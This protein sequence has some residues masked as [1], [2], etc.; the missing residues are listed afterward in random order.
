MIG[1]FATTRRG[2]RWTQWTLIFFAVFSFLVLLTARE[3]HHPILKRRRARQLGHTA[4]PRMPLGKMVSM[5]LT[6]SLVRPVRMLFTEPIVG[7]VCLYCSCEFATLFSFFASVPYVFSSVYGFTIEQQGLVFISILIGCGLGACTVL[8]CNSLLYLPR[9]KNYP[10]HQTPQEYRLYPAMLGGLGLPL[11]LFWFGW[12]ARSDV[13][14]AS[15][16]LAIMP[17][18]WGNICVFIATMQYMTDCYSGLTVAS[19]SSANSLSRYVFAG[20]LPLLTVQSKCHSVR[21][22]LRCRLTTSFQ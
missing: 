15:P 11:A 1:A 9:T 20:A 14:W 19:A 21:G 5:F 22:L 4:P 12:T 16:V 2:W 3:T 13:S 7:F 17:F 8:L 10:P 6:V 18:A